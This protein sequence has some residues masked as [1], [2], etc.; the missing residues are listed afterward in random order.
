ML[1]GLVVTDRAYAAHATEL[2][3]AAVARGWDARCFLTDTGVLLLRDEAFVA[4]ARRRPGTVAACKHSI[5]LHAP[6]GLD[7]APLD[8]AV[9]IGGQFQGARLAAA[10]TAMLV[11]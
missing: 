1:F 6:E 11:L 7:L 9:V 5:E 8:G 4:C 2:L 10:A 3:A